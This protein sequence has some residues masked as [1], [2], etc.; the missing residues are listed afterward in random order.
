MI[1][2]YG[3]VKGADY[4]NAFN[5][6]RERRNLFMLSDWINKIESLVSFFVNSA[7]F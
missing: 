7:K 1:I 4:S 5:E 3:S 6:V 2:E